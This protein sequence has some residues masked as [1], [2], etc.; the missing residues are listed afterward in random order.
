MAQ[1]AL[2]R[3]D[4]ASAAWEA[5]GERALKQLRAAIA[6]ETRADWNAALAHALLFGAWAAAEGLAPPGDELA[7]DPA[8]RLPAGAATLLACSFRTC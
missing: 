6:L 4:N 5:A 3:W 1:E 2:Q 8:W 7:A